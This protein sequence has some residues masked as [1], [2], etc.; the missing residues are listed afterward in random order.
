MIGSLLGSSQRS[1][2]PVHYFQSGRRSEQSANIDSHIENR[3]TCITL[4]R[5]LRIV[6]KIAHHYL[7]IA[8][9]QARSNTNHQ[10]G[11]HHR[12]EEHT[13]ELQSRQYLVCRLLLEKK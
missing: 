1:L 9:K 2:S 11:S 3:E 6:V 13:S 10:Q 7:Q 8:F 5:I 4:R 12:S